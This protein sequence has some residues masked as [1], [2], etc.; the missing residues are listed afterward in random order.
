[1]FLD[2][3]KKLVETKLKCTELSN[4]TNGTYKVNVGA[5]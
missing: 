1:M 3:M 2:H 4:L 5:V